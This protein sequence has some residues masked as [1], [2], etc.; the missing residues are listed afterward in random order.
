MLLVDGNIKKMDFFF[1]DKWKQNNK[2]KTESC[3]STPCLQRT[4][5][6]ECIILDEYLQGENLETL[7]E[8]NVLKFRRWL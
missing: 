6:N 5:K 7:K 1:H 4:W 8:E 2:R 3:M